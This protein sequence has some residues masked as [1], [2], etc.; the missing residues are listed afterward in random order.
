[1]KLKEKT[2]LHLCKLNIYNQPIYAKKYETNSTKK[3]KI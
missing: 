1:M 2:E 3:D